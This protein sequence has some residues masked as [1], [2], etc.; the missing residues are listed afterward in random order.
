MLLTIA[1]DD[2]YEETYLNCALF[3]AKSGI[4]ATFAVSSSLIG[5]NWKGR[6]II[7][8]AELLSLKNMGHEIA[9]HAV[10]HRNLVD[11]L[12]SEGKRAAKAEMKLSKEKFEEALGERIESFVFP[13]I[14]N[15]YNDYLIK[16]ASEYYS[17][18]RVTTE[19]FAINELPLKKP[20]SIMGTAI[21]T[22]RPIED[23]NTFLD[24]ISGEKNTWLIEVFHLVADKN[25]KT[26]DSGEP[27]RFFTSIEDFKKHIQYILT[28]NL[29]IMSQKEVISKKW[30]VGSVK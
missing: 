24:K 18:S 12:K 3:L 21:T 22:N 14:E 11:V 8:N 20:F 4:R 25:V 1:F 5:K 29:P 26:T 17:S 30:E 2:C 19:D 10:T 6:A 28:K 7:D 9:S 16:A 23:Y 13:Y 15:S 27:Y